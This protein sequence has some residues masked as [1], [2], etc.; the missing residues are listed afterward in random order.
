M[1]ASSDDET[2]D[3]S[4]LIQQSSEPLQLERSVKSASSQ[5]GGAP[6]TTSSHGFCCC[7]SHRLTSTLPEL[8]RNEGI[9][10]RNEDAPLQLEMFLVCSVVTVLLIRAGLYATGYPQLGGG[11]I[12][13]AHMLWGGLLMAISQV[14]SIAFLGRRVQRLS[15]VLGGIG[16]GAFIDELGKFITTSND[17]FFKPTPFL[18][19]IGFCVLF[20]LLKLVE[21]CFDPKR[22]SRS[23]NL[24]N[25]LALMSI[26]S[27]SGL[28]KESRLT[29][30][31]L[32]THADDSHPIVPALRSYVSL[33]VAESGSHVH[34][35]HYYLRF[36]RYI[37]GIYARMVR[38][39]YAT[40]AMVTFF[41]LQCVTQMVDIG[42]L[43]I[44]GSYY[45]HTDL[46]DAS[47]SISD[48]SFWDHVLA[49]PTMKFL[50]G[51]SS[52]E[53]S[54]DL[55]EETD[56]V[57]K[58]HVFQLVAIVLSACFVTAGVYQ[59]SSSMCR[60]CRRNSSHQSLPGLHLR[61]QERENKRELAFV[62]FRRSML[63]RL[64][65][66]DSLA[67]YHAQFTA[68]GDVVFTMSIV[69]ALSFMITQEETTDRIRRLSS[70]GAILVDEEEDDSDDM[71][72]GMGTGT[73]MEM[74]RASE[75]YRAP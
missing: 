57:T 3:S 18:L 64:F 1:Y 60:M 13:I 28:S 20:V 68:F 19:Y 49:S 55:M 9:L 38:N 33:P 61:V 6:Q 56:E 37:A 10:M 52:G 53:L 7:C 26:H 54:D 12:H 34:R 71:G 17:Y 36:R 59:L 58:I 2:E 24:A 42:Y 66:T 35:D 65:L 29:L 47:D 70:N 23:E 31:E 15:S 73:G 27:T 63:V 39:K 21:P 40:F 16:F 50:R 75:P 14:L 32:L 69:A 4:L 5:P 8:G 11:E 46:I 51:I 25:A 74:T 44:D 30:V 41:I 62:W 48:G 45:A 22:F 72:M 67:L 43:I